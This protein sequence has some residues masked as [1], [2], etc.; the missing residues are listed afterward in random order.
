MLL[1]KNASVINGN[2]EKA[3]DN[4][5]ILIEGNKIKQISEFD[6]IQ[7]NPNETEVIDCSGKTVMPGLIDAHVH[8]IYRDVREPYSIEL[9]RSLEEATADAFLNAKELVEYGITTVRDVG[10]RGKISVVVRE[11]VKQGKFIGPSIKASSRIIS[12]PGGL[13]DFHPTHIFE[14]HPYQYGLGEL[15]LGT[16][17]AR[18]AVRRMIK[19]GVDFIKA[20]CS[21]TGFNPL[22]PA[23]RNTLSFE[24][25]SAIVDEAKQNDLYVA[26]HAESYD[27][28]K[29]AAKAG[30][31]D[32]QHGIY[33]DDEGL[34]LMVKNNVWLV[35]TLAMYWGF[36]EKGPE[37]GIP[38]TII[39]GHLRTH[40]FHVKSIQKC[41]DAGITI[42]AG[43]D[44]GLVHFPQGGVRDEV[45]R[46]AEIGMS[47]MEAI[48]TATI[49]AARCLGVASDVGTIEE[50][51]N[52][53]ILILNSDPLRDIKILKEPKNLKAVIKDG[54]LIKKS[55]FLKF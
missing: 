23:E 2:A 36:I 5:S 37:L 29:K 34:E 39:N 45:V 47:P 15:I 44:A 14:N 53:D 28:V 12:T 32:I 19:D 48:K 11:M 31:H 3:I 13:G 41:I 52:A 27:S 17:Q 46:F 51:K 33:I 50:G 16:D 42:V 35:P 24:E 26:C 55:Q 9:E 38:Q 54:V 21:G 22:C 40:E 7:Y 20:E 49:N 30:V 8:L 25:I 6:K 1:L 18:C 10:T 43:S 4:Q